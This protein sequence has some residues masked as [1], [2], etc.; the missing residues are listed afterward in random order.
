MLARGEVAPMIDRCY[1][2]SELPE[3]L[4][5]LEKGHAR[6]KVVIKILNSSNER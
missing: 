2:L 5:Y 4:Q 1:S 3:A 6:G